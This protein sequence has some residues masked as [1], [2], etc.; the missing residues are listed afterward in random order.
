MYKG[1]LLKR[2]PVTV[3]RQID[4]V[5]KQLWGKAILSQ[6]LTNQRL[7]NVPSRTPVLQYL[8]VDVLPYESICMC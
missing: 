8:F 2:N 1:K 7:S 4:Y 3:A 6:V 5:L